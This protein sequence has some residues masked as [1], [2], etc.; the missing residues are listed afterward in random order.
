MAHK[1]INKGE[2]LCEYR[3]FEVNK[4]PKIKGNFEAQ[5]Y[6]YD[7]PDLKIVDHSAPEHK[8]KID[9]KMEEK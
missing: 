6:Y 8:A 5:R 1:L 7:V 3:G 2:W 4:I 9:K